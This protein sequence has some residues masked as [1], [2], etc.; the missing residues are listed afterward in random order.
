MHKPAL[1][2]APTDAR[3]LR[4]RALPAGGR[5]S[6]T[7]EAARAAW[8]PR[9]DATAATWRELEWQSVCAGLRP[10]AIVS[11]DSNSLAAYTARWDAEA[12]DWVP[13]EIDLNLDARTHPDRGPIRLSFAVLRKGLQDSFV[14]AWNNGRR[15]EIAQWLG[16]PPCCAEAAVR[17][18][19][20]GIADPLWHI[21]MATPSRRTS[22]RMLELECSPACNI[23]LRAIGI[24]MLAHVP[25]RLDCGHSMDLAARLQAFG[26]DANCG[27]S[28][29]WTPDILAWPMQWSAW[30]GLA[31]IRTP[32]CRISTATDYSSHRYIVRSHGQGWPSQ[33]AK[34]LDFPYHNAKP[35]RLTKASGFKRGLALG[36]QSGAPDHSDM[37]ATKSDAPSS[38]EGVTPAAAQS[39]AKFP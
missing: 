28:L 17:F 13:L 31:E 37:G 32:V 22:R 11:V 20:H 1:S 8:Q 26:A 38:A 9:F 19:R 34:G 6:W 7:S 12:L 15:G 5:I 39:A 14:E 30:H 2:S 4:Q 3:P 21:A 35:Y 27:A 24:R 29:D 25:C 23:L 10:A 33:G 18:W 36:S 16:A